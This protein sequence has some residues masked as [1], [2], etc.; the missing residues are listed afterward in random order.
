MHRLQP[1]SHCIR[2]ENE[3]SVLRLETF[4][5]IP[6]CKHYLSNDLLPR[7]P[8]AGAGQRN[9]YS[10]PTEA[11]TSIYRTHV[12]GRSG[13]GASRNQSPIAHSLVNERRYFGR[14]HLSLYS[15][16]RFFA[17]GLKRRNLYRIQSVCTLQILKEQQI[18]TRAVSK[19][20]ISF[21]LRRWLYLLPKQIL[22]KQ[23][24]PPLLCRSGSRGLTFPGVCLL[25]FR[26]HSP[27]RS[28]LMVFAV[29]VAL[30]FNGCE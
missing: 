26:M 25:R 21:T 4:S 3:V 29:A 8:R 10:L 19:L 9:F 1:N 16:L 27:Y 11:L 15:V 17:I 7:R 6:V 22:A 20:L 13:N 12:D 23:G 14:L 28:H 18:A 24:R 30:A 5:N 2:N